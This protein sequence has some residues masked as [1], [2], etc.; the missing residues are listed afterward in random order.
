[1]IRMELVVDAN[2]VFAAFIKESKSAELLFRDDFRFY[3]P[4][5]L[6]QEILKHEEE[7]WAKTHRTRHEFD[8]IVGGVM[9]RI[10]L[11]PAGDF[12]EFLEEAKRISPDQDDFQYFALAIKLGTGIWSNDKTLK[13]Q[14]RVRIF[15]TSEL[16]SL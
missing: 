15:S 13:K 5:F 6:F 16:T 10:A 14:A 3:A 8:E 12:S 1:M 7:L 2:V 11:I 4:E 9:R